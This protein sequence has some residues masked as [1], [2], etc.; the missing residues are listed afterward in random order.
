MYNLYT[1]LTCPGKNRPLVSHLPR[2][3]TFLGVDRP[4]YSCKICLSLYFL[5]PSYR[6]IAE[7]HDTREKDRYSIFRMRSANY[8]RVVFT[9]ESSFMRKTRRRSSYAILFPDC[10]ALYQDFLH[11]IRSRGEILAKEYDEQVYR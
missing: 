9:P 4:R 5:F 8:S 6:T 7:F 1:L 3:K 10:I 2:R 11:L